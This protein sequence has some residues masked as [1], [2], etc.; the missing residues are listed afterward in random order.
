MAL[1]ISILKNTLNFKYMHV[2]KCEI[3]ETKVQAYGETQVQKILK[4]DARPFRR[5]QGLCPKCKKMFFEWNQAKTRKS[6][7]SA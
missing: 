3:I 4:V 7:A 1:P 6:L 2:K 5:L